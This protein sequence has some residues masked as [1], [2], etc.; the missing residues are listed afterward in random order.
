MSTDDTKPDPEPTVAL[1]APAGPSLLTLVAVGTLT[2][3]A[4]HLVM[5]IFRR[6]A[7]SASRE[8]IDE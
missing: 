8:E 3:L 1:P 4:A 7:R 2:S 5:G 6:E